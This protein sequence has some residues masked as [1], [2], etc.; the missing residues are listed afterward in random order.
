MTDETAIDIVRRLT[1]E[2]VVLLALIEDAQRV[3]AAS[4]ARLRQLR[5]EI[6]R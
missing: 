3:A 5:E 2:A 1:A 4:A 6:G